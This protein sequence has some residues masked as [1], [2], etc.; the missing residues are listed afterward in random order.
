MH[1]GKR[2]IRS[3]G[4]SSGSIEVTLP[5][6]LAVLEGV[7]CR[8]YL[9][10]GLAPE[11]VMQPDLQA[12]MPVFE[13]LWDLLR[14]GLEE[15]DEIG[16]FSEADYSFG[17]FRAEKL[18]TMPSLAYADALLIRRSP[19]T[20]AETAP[21]VLE[22]FARIIESMAAVAGGRLG[23]PGNLVALFG[24]QVATLVSG[25]T[26]GA[27]DA[28]ARS[29]ASQSLDGAHAAGWCRT[30]PLSADD[31]RRARGALM[32]AYDQFKSWGNDPAVFAK[33]RELWYRARR[34]EAHTSLSRASITG[35]V[36][37]ET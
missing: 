18:G 26:I 33:E 10:D 9:R 29:F 5:V 8:L 32:G 6:E 17:L 34:F 28:F 20:A 22:A 19:V 11:I 16:D 2:N 3:A 37:Q 4:R 14:L 30:A 12:I 35:G 15:I 21:P 25:E 24:N 31:W 1:F 36:N 7:A 23:L 27:R 13:K